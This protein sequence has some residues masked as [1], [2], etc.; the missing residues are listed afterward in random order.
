MTDA[1]Q[2][3][4]LALTDATRFQLDLT[5]AVAAQCVLIGH[6]FDFFNVFSFLGRPDPPPQ[7]QRLAVVVFFLLSGFLIARTLHRH[8]LEGLGFHSYL[9]DRAA[10]I[11]SGLIPALLAIAVIDAL[12]FDFFELDYFEGDR[13]WRTAL[14]NLLHLQL[15]PGLDVPVFGT[16]EPLWTLAIE[17]WL[18][19]AAG[20]VMLAR[21]GQRALALLLLPI[22]AVSV[23][24]NLVGGEGHGI[25]LTWLLGAGVYGLLQRGRRVSTNDSYRTSATPWAVGALL[26]TA[27]SVVWAT[28][29]DASHPAKAFD[30]ILA[31][32]LA[33][34]FYCL[35]RAT[36]AVTWQPQAALKRPVV[37]VAS[38]SY[39]L[40]LVH[41]SWLT[42]L[43]Q[44][45]GDVPDRW[46]LLLGVVSSNLLAA[47]LALV[48]E[49]QRGRWRR[50]MPL[51]RDTTEG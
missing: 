38:Y 5:R 41:F 31:L 35:L 47:L 33:I 9:G 22:A 16:G 43:Y 29:L 42:V 8:R 48:G 51:P 45:R 39:T 46:L 13:S 44:W 11:Y 40:Y 28:Q 26:A 14:G 17:W 24:A 34:V 32:C 1:S 19:V 30:R 3:R 23:V 4:A 15:Y 36:Q 37:A 2:S 21:P 49:R 27:L 6:A 20:A 12:P 25:A 10:R 18:Y 7:I 50:F